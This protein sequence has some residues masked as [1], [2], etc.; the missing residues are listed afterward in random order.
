MWWPIRVAVGGQVCPIGGGGLFGAR[1]WGG[2]THLISSEPVV[3]TFCLYLPLASQEAMESSSIAAIAKR[4]SQGFHAHVSCAHPI[5]Q[6]EVLCSASTLWHEICLHVNT[7]AMISLVLPETVGVPL[8]TVYY[9]G[10]IPTLAAGATHAWGGNL[11][12]PCSLAFGLQSR[13]THSPIKCRIWNLSFCCSL[14][15]VLCSLVLGPSVASKPF[16]QP[17]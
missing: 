8:P 4:R 7:P 14:L 6:P 13:M 16:L 9:Y 15:G 10:F 11:S 3:Y 17:S 2:F 1:I 5:S 12:L